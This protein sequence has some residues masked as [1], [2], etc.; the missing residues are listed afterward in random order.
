[1]Y[2]QSSCPAAFSGNPYN[3]CFV[4]YSLF[5]TSLWY[6][7]HVDIPNNTGLRIVYFFINDLDERAEDSS[8]S[9]LRTQRCEN[10][11]I[12]Q[13]AV[14]PFTRTG[15][16]WRDGQRRSIW[17]SKK[18][19]AGGMHLE[20]NN[21]RHQH[22]LGLFCWICNSAENDLGV[23]VD[24]MLSLRQIMPRGLP[25]SQG[26]LGRPL[27]AGQLLRWPCPST[28]PWWG[29]SGPDTSLSSP[30][31]LRMRGIWS[32]WSRSSRGWQNILGIGAFLL[33][34]KAEGTGLVQPQEEMTER[35]PH[36]FLLVSE[37]E[38][39]DKTME[40]GSWWCQAIEQGV[41]TDTQEVPAEHEEECLYWAYD[42]TMA[43]V[44]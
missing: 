42:W 5:L 36:Q 7:T 25:V 4:C 32:S 15:T 44:G 12:A 28:Q 43:Q 14:Q 26:A 29:I 19:N 37:Y 34:G 24:S 22:R 20:R 3:P 13:R 30:E 11:L 23:L 39:E 38:Y 6:V 9:S 2:C 27:P 17:N 41:E 40:P 31:L 16:G 21:L 8:A 33:W 1:M 10:W 35:E 18:A